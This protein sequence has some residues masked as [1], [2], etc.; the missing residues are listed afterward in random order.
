MIEAAAACGLPLLRPSQYDP[1]HATSF[2]VG[3]LIKKALDAGFRKLI[4]TIGGTATMEGGA[5]CLQALGVHFRNAEGK[6]LPVG[7]EP[8]LRL[9][10]MDDLSLDAR[11][12]ASEVVVLS[13]VTTILSQAAHIFAAQ[14][15]AKVDEIERIDQALNHFGQILDQ[16]Y[17]RAFSEFPGSGA[18]GGFGTGLAAITGQPISRG[19]EQVLQILEIDAKLDWC[20]A[21]VTSEGKLDSQTMQGKAIQG[22]AKMAKRY[23]KPVHAFVGRVEGDRE[24]LKSAL[25]LASLT[26][27]SRDSSESSLNQARHL[28]QEAV[29]NFLRK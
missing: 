1:L 17:K 10:S 14:K 5:G 27:I 2:G 16:Y 22:L 8:L 21:V 20:D 25:G 4:I 18:A 7:C 23:G 9:A 29:F 3:Q 24:Q 6:E 19:V 13:D 15:G 12:K 26:E 11:W 28:L